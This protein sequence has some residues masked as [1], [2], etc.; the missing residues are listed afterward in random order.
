MVPPSLLGHAPGWPSTDLM[1]LNDNNKA[2]RNMY[3][4]PTGGDG[5]SAC[6][7]ALVRNAATF[8]RDV[9]LDF[10]AADPRVA[11]QLGKFAVQTVGERGVKR[12]SSGR[13]VLAGMEPG[14][15]R[16]V[17]LTVPART[18]TGRTP[19]PVFFDEVVGTR[20]VNGFA[21]APVPSP[22]TA[23]IRFNAELTQFRFARM[24][25]LLG[26]AEAKPLS[27][28]A[29][30]LAAQ[31]R[32]TGPMYVEFLGKLMKPIAKTVGGV[33]KSSGSDPFGL[34]SAIDR[35]EQA[36]AGGSADAVAPAHLCFLG[37]LDAFL[38]TLQLDRGDPASVLHNVEW[39][40]DLFTE[41]EALAGLDGAKDLVKLSDRFI[42][43]WEAR[44]AGPDQ[45]PAF[46]K[47]AAPIL[48]TIAKAAPRLPL[49]RSLDTLEKSVGSA[50]EAQLA[51]RDVLLRL[52][53]LR[54]ES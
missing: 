30:K 43:D 18:G 15:R 52:S 20:V 36:V 33:V 11:K 22:L 34:K 21:I 19:L 24:A 29:R 28:E 1:V 4:P 23:A 13:Q 16:W 50:A 48:R 14:E 17:S 42:R 31:K 12:S 41:V 8:R 38:T 3:P 53:A 9:V 37:G 2:Q 32:L 7:Y 10:R 5:S 51:H 45:F 27:A 46:V 44:K 39:Q 49:V 25:E 47:R 6:F 40:R 26:L 54:K 35:L